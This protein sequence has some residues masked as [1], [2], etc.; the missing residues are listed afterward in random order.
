MKS[1]LIYN[2]IVNGILNDPLAVIFHYCAVLF[3]FSLVITILM[4]FNIQF[5]KLCKYVAI[6]IKHTHFASH[7]IKRWHQ[8]NYEVQEV[9]V[10]LFCVLVL[11]PFFMSINWLLITQLIKMI[12][13]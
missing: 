3:E 13:L 11:M 1:K 7:I 6:K 4:V 8:L 9:I 12:M 10:F 5:Y 2:D